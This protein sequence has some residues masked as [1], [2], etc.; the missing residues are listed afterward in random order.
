MMTSM[1]DVRQTHISVKCVIASHPSSLSPLI[2]H[3]S[4]LSALFPPVANSLPPLHPISSL[5]PLQSCRSAHLSRQDYFMIIIIIIIP[6]ITITISI[7]ILIK[8]NIIKRIIYMLMGPSQRIIEHAVTP[9]ALRA[10]LVIE[11]IA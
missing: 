8:T 3:L 5:I 10:L 11:P 4:R 6:F 7:I 1:R 9:R 2:P